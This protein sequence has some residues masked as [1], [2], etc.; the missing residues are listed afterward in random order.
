V[1]CKISRSGIVAAIVIKDLREFSRDRLWMILAPISLIF[2]IAIYF[3]APDTV[4]E[5]IS[6]GVYPG[7][8]AASF[9]IL[10]GMEGVEFQGLEITGFSDEEQLS[11]AVFGDSPD[12]AMGIAL[13]SGFADSLRSGS[14]GTVTVYVNASVPVELR[15]ALKS[16]I[17]EIAFAMRASFTGNNPLNSLPV[18]L[19]DPET[20]ILGDNMAGIET[21][22]REKI[23][24]ILVI[25]II[26]IEAL[27]LAGLVSVEI[28]HKTATAILITPARTMDLLAAKCITGTI[29]TVSQ[30]GLFLAATGGFSTNWLITSVLILLGAGMASAIGMLSGTWGRDFMSTLFFGMVFVIPL[31]IPV[32]FSIIPGEPPLIV[33]LLPSYGLLQSMSG[34]LERAEGWSFA[35]PGILSTLVW[36]TLLLGSAIFFLRRRVESL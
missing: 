11:N 18:T 8:I 28:E 9:S 17:R 22:L 26:F 16:G 1:R 19:P 31:M 34:V 36:D 23:R 3:L 30:A 13:P 2:M 20:R 29:L 14:G 24:P 15:Q 33:R 10:A 7:N 4:T 6:I 35:A 25:M 5:S 12:I 32:F 27:A 21:P